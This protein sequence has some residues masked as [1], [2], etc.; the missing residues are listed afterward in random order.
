V[1]Y[2]GKFVTRISKRLSEL[3]FPTGVD[4]KRDARRRKEGY[5]EGRKRQVEAVDDSVGIR[6]SAEV[7]SF[8]LRVVHQSGLEST[9]QATSGVLR[10]QSG[11][12]HV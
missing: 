7:F 10:H 6:G 5:A 4:R 3:F 1:R 11:R 12:V 9:L 2:F 8:L